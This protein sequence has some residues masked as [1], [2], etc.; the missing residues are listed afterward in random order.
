MNSVQ[1]DQ[2]P[3][4][5][6]LARVLIA[7]DNPIVRSMLS[8]SLQ[9]SYE[10]VASV[11]DAEAA[12]SEAAATLPDGAVVY[13]DMPGGASRGAGD[14]RSFPANRDRRPLG[15]RVQAG[16]DRTVERW[17]DDIHP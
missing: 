4:D 2:S 13:V 1:Q 8:M 10:V 14:S 16:R 9:N 12:V 11:A 7:D 6:R 17:G 15:G 5:P 3:H